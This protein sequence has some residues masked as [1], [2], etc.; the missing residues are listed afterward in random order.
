KMASIGEF[1][2]GVAHNLR[3]PLSVI[4]GYPELVLYNLKNG[5][6]EEEEL[7]E[8]M[9][10]IIENIKKCFGIIDNILEFSKPKT[11]KE[12]I[13]IANIIDNTLELI[14]SNLLK[15][16]IE[17]IKDLK[18][19]KV[20]GNKN[21]LM[22]VFINIFTNAR[23]AMPEGGKLFIKTEEN[24]KYGIIR[25]KDTGIGIKKEYINR[26]FEPF[27][28]TKGFTDGSGIGL[29]MCQKIINEHKGFIEVHSEEGIGTTITLKLPISKGFTPL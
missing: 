20:Y 23:D 24:K 5:S 19:Y 14:G 15:S 11:N 2:A 6:L 18:D 4:K 1:S 26:I 27:F 22:Q 17:I 10:I 21:Q 16:K 29:S 7:K 9:E 25:V 13:S 12:Y 8:W 3:S 28:T